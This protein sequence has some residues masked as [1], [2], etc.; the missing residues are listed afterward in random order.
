MY[1]DLERIRQAL[2][3]IA[4]KHKNEVDSAEQRFKLKSYYEFLNYS[5]N[6]F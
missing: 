3:L 2:E 5:F 1:G 6:F 4:I